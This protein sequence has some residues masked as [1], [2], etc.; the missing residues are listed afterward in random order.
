MFI[1]WEP[2]SPEL[3][4]ARSAW[5]GTSLGL[6]RDGS[7][8]LLVATGSGQ[9][10]MSSSNISCA[11]L[12]P[13]WYRR[14]PGA[15]ADRSRPV[16]SGATRRLKSRRS[17]LRAT[18]RPAPGGPI[19]LRAR[20]AQDEDHAGRGPVGRRPVVGGLVRRRPGPAFARPGPSPVRAGRSG[21][22]A[23]ASGSSRRGR[24]RPARTKLPAAAR[25][26]PSMSF[27]RAVPHSRLVTMNP[28]ESIVT[29]WTQCWA[30]GSA[31]RTAGGR[32]GP[33]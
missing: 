4:H 19:R 28:P 11:V 29:V 1:L 33:D 18:P 32:A 13:E 17:R 31:R 10:R 6:G 14:M 27:A 12:M 30:S 22:P 16:A 21:R 9:S 8:F 2:A 3:I 7:A 5:Q 24:R 23:R 15:P 20:S 25:T 26:W